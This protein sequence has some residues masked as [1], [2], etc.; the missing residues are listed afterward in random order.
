VITGLSFGAPMVMTIPDSVPF[1]YRNP[2]WSFLSKDA[3]SWAMTLLNVAFYMLLAAWCRYSITDGFLVGLDT[4]QFR[5]Y[6]PFL[7]GIVILSIG[8]IGVAGVEL[9]WRRIGASDIDDM[10]PFYFLACTGAYIAVPGIIVVLGRKLRLRSAN[11]MGS[12]F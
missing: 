6:R 4:V 10:V 11:R 9:Y 1:A 7:V 12:V 8:C 5:R 3:S 2:G